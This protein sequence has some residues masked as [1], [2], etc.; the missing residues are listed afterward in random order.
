MGQQK[1]AVERLQQIAQA[2]RG[3]GQINI[4][5]LGCVRA[6]TGAPL[7]VFADGASAVPGV[8]IT[9]SE[10]WT[11]RWN[12]HATP[13]GIAT[14]IA[15]PQD[16]DWK[17]NIDFHAIVSKSG[18]TLADASTLTVVAYVN[19]VGALHDADADMGG[20]TNAIVGNAAAKTTSEVIRTLATANLVAPPAFLALSFGPTAGLL[21]TDDL[22][23]HAAWLEYTRK[24]A[25]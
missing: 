7:A 3:F 11:V 12:N 2:V 21:G 16:L 20:A 18:A 19:A 25:A 1:T 17:Y 15:L 10:T 23:L 9:N 4:N 13:T 24:L 14:T 6:D 8:Q 5:H 22:M